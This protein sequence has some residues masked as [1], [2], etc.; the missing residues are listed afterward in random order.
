M[1]AESHRLGSAELGVSGGGGISSGSRGRR[2]PGANAL[3]HRVKVEPGAS[4]PSKGSKG[5]LR[6]QV[7]GRG[8][9][10]PPRRRGEVLRDPSG[11][12]RGWSR[13]SQRV[14]WAGWLGER[15]Q[16]GPQTQPA[17]MET[18]MSQGT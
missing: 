17:V 3:Y 15:A 1:G 2:T 8:T 5:D 16:S 18:R 7:R 11:E 9:W 13:D 14:G 4:R 10:W 6:T 12:E